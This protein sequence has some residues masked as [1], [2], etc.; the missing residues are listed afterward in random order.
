MSQFFFAWTPPATPW[1][2]ALQR[3]DE[4]IVSFSIEHNEGDIP[5]MSVIIKNPKVGLLGAGRFYW[6]WLAWQDDGA[7]VHPLFFGRLVGVP[8]DTLGEAITLKFI[9]R[10]SN[11]IR[12]KQLVAETLKVLPGYD[13]VFAPANKLDDPDVILE[14]YSLM[15]HVDRLTGVVSVSDILIGEDGTL[16]YG[17][18]TAT[19]ASLKIHLNQSPLNAV[20]VQAV[21]NWDQ[22]HRG[23]FDVTYGHMQTFTGEAFISDWPQSGKSLGGGWHAAIGWAA[24]ADGAVQLASAL[25]NVSGSYSWQNLGKQHHTGDTMSVNISYS[26]NAMDGAY[27]S[28]A[29]GMGG[30]KA[31]IYKRQQIGL[32]IPYTVDV[33]GDPAPVNIPYQL[34]V[35]WMEVVPWTVGFALT[36]GYEANRKRT[37]FMFFT[38]QADTQQVIT[39]P[40]ITENTEVLSLQTSNLSMPEISFL[41]WDSVSGTAVAVGTVVFPNDPAV[42]GQTSTQICTTAGTSGIVEPLFSNIAGATTAD[43][44]AVWTSYGNTPPAESASDWTR[45]INVAL[46]TLVIPMPIIAEDINSILTQGVLTWPPHGVF[47]NLYRLLSDGVSAPGDRIFE[48]TAAGLLG[49][50]GLVPAPIFAEF[51]NP[52]GMVMHICTRAGQTGDFHTTFNEP[53]GAT[54]TDGTA[55]WTSL[56]PVTLPIGGWPGMTPQRSY[57]PSDRGQQ[58]LQHLICRARAKLRKRARA[59]QL[60]WECPFQ[61]AIGLSCRTNASISDSRIPGGVA[62][63]KVIAY[64]IVAQGNTGRLYGEVT[65]G[66]TVGNAGHVAP[67]SG[68]PEYVAAGYVDG[69]QAYDGQVVTFGAGDIGYTPP[70]ERAVDDGLVFPLDYRQ[71][72]LT[73][74]FHGN[75]AFETAAV[76]EAIYLAQEAAYNHSSSTLTV[77]GGSSVSVSYDHPDYAAI[78]NQMRNA[79]LVGAGTWYELSLKPLTNGPF[80]DAYQVQTTTLHLPKTIDLSAPT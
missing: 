26:H 54:T 72:V 38:L 22:R 37:E 28:P 50:A 40:L 21:A 19:Y 77:T 5:T 74:Q 33:N 31:Q 76:Q 65:I 52:T 55:Q 1:S 14:G 68:T 60:S 29:P 15:Y 27:S 2:S 63:G 23:F 25:G 56:G 70:V 32:Q 73:N 39:D 7:T 71:A 49:G 10:P 18:G 13:R 9:A 57:F 51:T 58:S 16:T 4:H 59:V 66:C 36:L 34:D 48:C 42:P 12:Q 45:D 20:A 17:G 46:G 64:K 44:T 61:N 69:Y 43:G 8:T 3:F 24:N 75:Y 80:A 53:L 35:S 47:I 78:Q 62:T 41:N 30:I 6:A 11:Y 67:S 79:N